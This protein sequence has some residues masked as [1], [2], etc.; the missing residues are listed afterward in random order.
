MKNVGRL[1]G[2]PLLPLP[3]TLAG[4]WV[5]EQDQSQ[6][7]KEHT[8]QD[9]ARP[10]IK[11]VSK[12]ETGFF[13]I[14]HL[15]TLH[16]FPPF[17]LMQSLGPVNEYRLYFGARASPAGLGASS[18]MQTVFIDRSLVCASWGIKLEYYGAFQGIFKVKQSS[19]I[20]S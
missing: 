17:F 18:K 1:D 19:F 2:A 7:C 20:L 9:L 11:S 13:H 15:M 6:H 3:N 4:K 16:E 8:H 5:E 14:R 12:W 10:K